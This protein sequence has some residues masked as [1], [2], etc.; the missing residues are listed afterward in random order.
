LLGRQFHA[1]PANQEIHDVRHG[2][3]VRLA[4]RLA[5]LLSGASMFLSLR[6]VEKT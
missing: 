2:V 1:A 6:L 4:V 5:Q 3:F